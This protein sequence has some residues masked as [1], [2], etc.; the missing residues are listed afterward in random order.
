MLLFMS[1]A[2]PMLWIDSDLP[3]F[4]SNLFKK[5]KFNPFPIPGL[6][7]LHVSP[8]QFQTKLIHDVFD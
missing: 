1:A 7:I 5:T 6:L 8:G 2:S 3:A 4:L